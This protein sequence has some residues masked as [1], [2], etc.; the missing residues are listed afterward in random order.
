MK[1]VECVRAAGSKGQTCKVCLRVKQKCGATWGDSAAGPSGSGLGA[2]GAVLASVFGEAGLKLLE[3]LVVGVERIGSELGRLHDKLEEVRDVLWEGADDEQK[4]VVDAGLHQV[5]LGEWDEMGRLAE[6]RG[7]EEENDLFRRFLKENTDDPVGSGGAG[8]D[9]E[10]RG[11]V[12]GELESRGEKEAPGDT[13]GEKEVG[14]AEVR[15]VSVCKYGK[16]VCKCTQK[17]FL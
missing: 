9:L 17:S 10:E 2:A 13:A 15:G 4:G 16:T 3:R 12:E 7:L 11:E 5:W 6:V 1:K 14:A 8:S